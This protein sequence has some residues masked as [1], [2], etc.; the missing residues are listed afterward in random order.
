MRY[1]AITKVRINAGERVLLSDAQAFDRRH[2]VTLPA[3][4][5]FCNVLRPFDFKAGE[6][7]EFD[8]ALPK[9]MALALNEEPAQQPAV[10]RAKAPK[11]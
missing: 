5:G 10:K 1:E 4:D 8:G 3:A 9:G 6:R 11:A 2:L 7:F